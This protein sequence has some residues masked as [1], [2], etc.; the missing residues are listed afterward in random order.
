MKCQEHPSRVH[1]NSQGDQGSH[2]FELSSLSK[3]VSSEASSAHLCWFKEKGFCRNCSEEAHVWLV[4]EK[5][6]CRLMRVC[7]RELRSQLSQRSSCH[8]QVVYFPKAL[9]LPCCLFSAALVSLTPVPGLFIAH[10]CL[11]LCLLVVL[12]YYPKHR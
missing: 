4:G 11:V 7:D 10:V 9:F 8:R 5:R 12:S 6:W 2:D 1:K 3:P